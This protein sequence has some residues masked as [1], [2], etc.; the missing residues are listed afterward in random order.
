MA[1]TKMD[2]EFERDDIDV[3]DSHSTEPGDV[4]FLSLVNLADSDHD[5]RR[6]KV[7]YTGGDVERRIA[8]LQT[9]N[10][11]QLR[12][13]SYFPSPVAR[14]LENWVHR[15]NAS[16]MRHLEWLELT[17]AEIPALVAAAQEQA[18]RLAEVAEAS[19]RWS[20]CVSNGEGRPPVGQE[21]DIHGEAQGVR[22]L[23]RRVS[24]ELKRVKAQMALHAGRVRRVPGV[25]RVRTVTPHAVFSRQ[26]AHQKFGSGVAA[27]Y[28]TEEVRG[29]F[30]WRNRDKADSY[31]KRLKA[32][33]ENLETQ[34]HHLNTE[35]L[36]RPE[37]LENDGKRTDEIIDLHQEYLRLTQQEA[38]HSVHVETLKARMIQCMEDFEVITGASSFNRR[39]KS[40]L[41]RENG[42]AFREDHPDEATQCESAQSPQVHRTIYKC[43]SY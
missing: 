33:V 23:L 11:Y 14:Q 28:L 5:F 42:E 27:P 10:P 22:S 20:R 36:Q 24:L 37:T 4:Y 38:L 16:Q 30:Q 34:V 17:R 7:G 31:S 12:C 2:D 35:I 15:A 29:R 9:G 18:I 26:I 19:A 6:V 21:R 8:Q 41:N 39:L 13:E 1:V 43:R 40:V 25:L 32:D 3:D